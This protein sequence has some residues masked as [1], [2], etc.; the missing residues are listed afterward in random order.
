MEFKD[1]EMFALTDL[2]QQ[3]KKVSIHVISSY[4]QPIYPE[5]LDTIDAYSFSK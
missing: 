5:G 4:S 2:K 3:E 1:F